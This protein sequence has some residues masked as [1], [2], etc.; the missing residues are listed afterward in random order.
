[1]PE[2]RI[3]KLT[4]RF[5]THAVGR[6]PENTRTRERHSLY[7]DSELI[8]SAGSAFKEVSHDLYPKTIS[9]SLFWETLLSYGLDHLSD[10]KDLLA[11]S[12][13]A[14]EAARK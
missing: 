4:E 7:L 3:S 1:M 6:R 8:S 10:I 13:A 2:D 14:S 5:K 9:K 11:K 12:A